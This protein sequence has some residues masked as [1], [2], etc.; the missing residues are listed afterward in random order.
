MTENDLYVYFRILPEEKVMV[1]INNNDAAQIVNWR[2]YQEVLRDAVQ[3][4]DIISEK[5][6]ILIKISSFRQK[7]V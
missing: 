6:S 5:V 1:I 2:D 3:G 4:K 7:R